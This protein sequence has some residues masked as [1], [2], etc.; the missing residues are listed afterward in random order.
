MIAI[1]E[2]KVNARQTEGTILDKDILDR[3]TIDITRSVP[4][5][6]RVSDTT[7]INSIRLPR[8]LRTGLIRDAQGNLILPPIVRA[9]DKVVDAVM[10]GN[11]AKVRDATG[12]FFHVWCANLR[13]EL[14]HISKPRNGRSAML[15][16]ICGYRDDMFS[17]NNYVEG[18]ISDLRPWQVG[19]T[20]ET[21][22]ILG[23]EEGAIVIFSRFPTTMVI[24]MEAVTLDI[25]PNVVALPV[26]NCLMGNRDTSAAKEI[27][28]D[29]DGDAYTIRTV[30]SEKAKAELRQAFHS[31]W[32]GV[33]EQEIDRTG[34][35][36]ADHEP[37]LSDPERIAAQKF[38]QKSAVGSTTLD[39]YAV[40]GVLMNANRRGTETD[41]TFEDVRAAMMDA[42]ESVFD[43]KHA[44]GANP[45]T[46]HSLLLG[47]TT[48]EDSSEALMKQGVDLSTVAKIVDLIGGASVREVAQAN[49]AYA[50]AYGQRDRS[51]KAIELLLRKTPADKTLAET[52]RRCL[53]PFNYET[54]GV[55]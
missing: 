51:D 44:N 27:G 40:F 3:I 21:M 25:S 50:I 19:L 53:F 30:N 48:I 22:E 47:M 45:M 9:F 14:V 10:S 16:G 7:T 52:F 23:I 34:Y 17:G 15:I 29:L 2:P 13:C 54:G 35:T 31:Y 18:N 49:P 42:L 26:N 6:V 8:G 43:L 24:P 33:W 36:W 38:L 4:G 55:R 20:T 28:G 46:L 12:R 37:R 39:W 1:G 32:D 41:L 5:G 11:G